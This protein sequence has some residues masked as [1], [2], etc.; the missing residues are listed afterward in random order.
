VTATELRKSPHWP[1]DV[2]ETEDV[3]DKYCP[4]GAAY[5]IKRKPPELPVYV[6]NPTTSEIRDLWV[7]DIERARQIVEAV[8]GKT[9]DSQMP[10]AGST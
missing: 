3:T 6:T 10:W 8:F 9:T 5:I 4:L 2:T 1:S 7:L